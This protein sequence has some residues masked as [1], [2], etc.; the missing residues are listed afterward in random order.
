VLNIN[1]SVVE[2]VGSGA[3]K[4]P[5][6]T[7]NIN[8]NYL[9]AGVNDGGDL[10]VGYFTFM[11]I[12]GSGWKDFGGAGAVNL[13]NGAELKIYGFDI[14]SGDTILQANNANLSIGEWGTK[15]SLVIEGGSKVSVAGGVKLGLGQDMA[16]MNSNSSS[17]LANV[18]NFSMVNIAG[19]KLDAYSYNSSVANQ[20]IKSPLTNYAM[21]T[22][23]GN[24]GTLTAN[25]LG[26]YEKSQ[27]IGSG[28]IILNDL[29]S[30]ATVSL[31]PDVD[32]SANYV[33][34]GTGS[35]G[36]MMLDEAELFIGDS[37]N[38]DTLGRR[39]GFGTLT[40]KDQTGTNQRGSLTIEDSTLAFDISKSQSDKLIIDGFDYC[41]INRNSFVVT[42]NG[43]QSG[44]SFVLIDFRL[45][46]DGLVGDL[47]QLLNL[48]LIGVK[49]ELTYDEAAMDVIF[50]VF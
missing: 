46:P 41:A 32:T 49:G 13:S 24:Q 36:F 21:Y 23:L 7:A 1:A 2:V 9:S 26:F 37:F 43:V 3:I 40:M 17:G 38:F 6:T 31:H 44:Q 20:G 12:G 34:N 18:S 45:K 8:S 47:E 29:F 25:Q 22:V 30:K 19:G 11:N 15:A 10:N 48:K 14:I 33:I 50:T 35:D 39:S 4:L 5:N 28:S 16:Q 27:I 42:G